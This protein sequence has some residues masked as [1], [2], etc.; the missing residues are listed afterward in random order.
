[1]VR[2]AP[3]LRETRWPPRV[4]S[5]RTS[6]P[7]CALLVPPRVT[8]H[9]AFAGDLR[10]PGPSG[11]P[12]GVHRGQS[13]TFE[14][15]EIDES[16]LTGE[17]VPVEAGVGSEVAGATVNTYGRLVVEARKV[18]ARQETERRLL[19]LAEVDAEESGPE[20]EAVQELRQQ[21]RDQII[22]VSRVTSSS[23]PT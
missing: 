5:K 16:L 14:N 11:R 21:D 20:D 23:G 17:S 12:P 7:L 22:Q 6:S 2:Q 15:L 9:G 4:S 8:G 3:R 13:L 10:V 1:M 19:V 18:V